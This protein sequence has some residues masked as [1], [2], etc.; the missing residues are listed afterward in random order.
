MSFTS[1]QPQVGTELT[2]SLSDPDG[3][4]TEV[5]WQWASSATA[6]G[7]FSDLSGNG[8]ATASYT[9]QTADID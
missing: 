4:V 9:P 5:G 1:S 8:A 6:D 2:A 3:E 7:A